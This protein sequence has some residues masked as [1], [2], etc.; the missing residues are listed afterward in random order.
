M[1]IKR[2]LNV[3]PYYD[4]FNIEKKYYR[5]LFKP[6]YAVQ[7]RE[8][9]Q[10]Q[11][12][13][14]NQIE[15]F[16]DNIFKEGSVI[17]GCTFTELKSLAY[18]K[19]TDAEVDG[20]P[21]TP[22]NYTD[23]SEFDEN[24][25]E[26]EY[27]FEVEGSSG[28]KAYIVTAT[29]G[30]QS[31]APDLNTFY[32][33]YLNSVPSGATD[34][35]LFSPGETLNV[36]RYK[37]TKTATTNPIT[38]V[39]T[40]TENP[41]VDDG[42]VATVSVASF[43]D[44]VGLSYGLSVTEGII[45]QRGHFLYSDAQTI[46]LTKYMPKTYAVGE[47]R[48]PHDISVGFMV[49]EE[50]I[51]SQ[52]DTSLLDNANG[53]ENENAPG[54]DRLK[55]SPVLVSLP[56]ADANAD[57]SFFTL[58]RYENG[59]ATLIRDVSQ[60][61]SISTEMAR[62]TFEESGDYVSKPF[63]FNTVRKNGVVNAQVG[64]G[65]VYSKGYRVQNNADVFLP[66]QDV[67]ST[68]FGTQNNQPVSFQYGGYFECIDESSATGLIDLAGFSRVNLLNSS[69]NVIGSAIVKDYTL[70]VTA[71]N[72]VGLN[73]STKGRLYVFGIRMVN[74]STTLSSVM[75]VQAPGATGKIKVDPNLKD[76]KNSKLVF[77][78]GQPFVK[79]VSDFVLFIRK[80]SE[81]QNVVSSSVTITPSAGETYTADCLNKI[82]V[83][84]QTNTRLPVTSRDIDGQG[85]IVLTI[86][87]QS[88][89]TVTVYHNARISPTSVRAKQ[90]LDCFV[91]TTFISSPTVKTKYTIGLPDVYKL[92]QITGT[93]SG[94][95]T[96]YTSSF[97][98]VPNQKDD[99][100]D[101]SYIELIAGKPTPPNGTVLTVKFSVFRPD[102]SGAYNF[103]TV[104]SYST[105]DPTLIP[106]FS[107]KSGVY[108]LR[109][110]IDL[111]PHRVPLT[112]IGY[113]TSS[114]SAPSISSSVDIELPA[115]NTELFST[116]QSYVYPA[117]ESPST[118]DIDYYYN[119]T[120]AIVASSLGYI[121]LVKGE[122]AAISRP[123]EV[124]GS[125]IIATV[126]VPGYPT[127]TM[128]EAKDRRK[129][130]Y[131]VDIRKY[132]IKN[133]T[134]KDIDDI[135]KKIDN[136]TYYVTLSQLEA[137]TQ[138]LLV[139]DA[140]GNTRF[141]NG[142][143][144]DP[145]NDLTIADINHQDFNAA[146]DFTE[147]S[148]SPS[149]Q[150]FPMNLKLVSATN[151]QS[152]KNILSTLSPDSSSVRLIGQETATNYRTCT[153]NFY[154]YNGEGF[155]SPEY[156]GAYDT[157]AEPM[158]VTI[159]LT[160]PLNSL[161][162]GIQEFLPLQSSSSRVVDSSSNT[163]RTGNQIIVDTTQTI[164]TT[165]NSLQSSVST[166]EQPV[167]DFVTNVSFEPFI[168]S[169]EVKIFVSGLRPNTRHYFFFDGVD[170]NANV[171]PAKESETASASNNLFDNISKS[172]KN[173]DAVRSDS[174]GQL[175]ASFFIPPEKFYVG[176]RK[177]EIVDVDDYESIA[178]AAQSKCT[179]TYHAYNFNTTTSALSISTR[180]PEYSIATSVTTDT[181][182]NRTVTTIPDNDDDRGPDPDP[183]G[184]VDPLAQTFFVKQN[185][186]GTNDCVYVSKIDLYFKRKSTVNGVT[187]ML[188]EVENGYPAYEILPFSKVHLKKSQV[189]VSEDGSVATTVTFSAPV[190]LN[191]EKEYC[192]VIMP[193]AAD[194]DYLIF[195]AKV[196]GTNL[197]TNEPIN[198]DWGDGVLF[199][200]TNDRAWQSYQDEDIK[201]TLYRYNFNTPTG[202]LT[203]GTNGPEFFTLSQYAN[204]FIQN[205]LVYALK[206]TTTF[207]AGFTAGFQT[208]TGAGIGSTYS[209]GDYICV[210]YPDG[211][212]DL[213]KVKSV[214]GN[215]NSLTTTEAARVT[216]TFAT[217]PC[218][219]A[220]VVNY[221]TYRPSKLILEESSAR[222][223][224][225]FATND[226]IIGLES[227]ATGKIS[228]I[229]NFEMSY[230]QP[231]IPRVTDK[232][233]AISLSYIAIDPDN[234]TDLPYEKPTVFNDKTAF[235]QK[236]AVIYSKSN[237]VNEQKGFKLKVSLN[238]NSTQT[239]TALVDIENA[240]MMV[241]K[242]NI[243]NNEN[244]PTSAYVSK[245]VTLA[246]GFD[247]ED[248]RLYVT[249]YLPLGSNIDAYIR[250]ENASDPLTIDS[251][252]WIPFDMISGRGVYSSTTNRNDFREYEFEI[253]NT[254]DPDD[255]Y[256]KTAGVIWYKN[257][258]GK[259][260]K[261]K[262]FQIKIVMRSN[263]VARVPRLLDYRGIAIE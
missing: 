23:Y 252:P 154:L 243:N 37:I 56:T 15:Q 256:G 71:V 67:S 244:N 179:L 2:D 106:T 70:P 177:L 186:A 246:D 26:V 132:G 42:I 123:P 226:S 168:R 124:K 46:V 249:A 163:T 105:I 117:Q 83:I 156:D 97:R 75:Y 167:G 151:T 95:T 141:K 218:V 232:K 164:Q 203:L 14:Q 228:T 144:V 66:I 136:L 137:E 100:Y 88:S 5:V 131:G 92:L 90:S 230:I 175:F 236:G 129:L 103:F 149:V 245:V 113:A 201:F 109:D 162:E 96:D 235:D 206:G 221:A 130:S 91:K 180:A 237:D 202:N 44:P 248:F 121:Y 128:Q 7:A 233:S 77:D 133:Y 120:D 108:D 116:S 93:T 32:V 20:T 69:E 114:G 47:Y 80:K 192:V 138:N 143:I 260:D 183:G 94:V 104:N 59:A 165:T 161:V 204:K 110:C 209:V 257:S 89:G 171:A 170:V 3:A 43:S 241:N 134:M 36:R 86:S 34:I 38:Q 251:N 107:G 58:R 210:P 150:T 261:Y 1:P 41:P 6:G 190:R 102:A 169:R 182:T 153:S 255:L 216:G 158:Q 215:N 135:N 19:L 13:L 72:T 142:I 74:N 196:G 259:Y 247:A 27:Y 81:N 4:D 242:Y 258:S 200:S 262:N 231:T 172:G 62:R 212:K 187:V 29:N 53:S 60:F 140:D 22:T 181:V 234:P 253:T 224:R 229:D 127:Y 50:I 194:P 9:T 193:D 240:M 87:G 63:R 8:L 147:R 254:D 173:G 157:V 68:S 54:A 122:E 115:Y 225:V 25:L 61:N 208:V 211:T 152:Y 51:N 126:Y 197:I 112:G 28:L 55:L 139:K 33:N 159:D 155:L 39:E 146:L 145:F 48:Q 217:R 219:A 239:S 24:G 214:A 222:S 10:L 250:I 195:T 191:V 184:R 85:R 189:N 18:V 65:I 213:L 78:L 35:K 207:S 188:R 178:S 166:L 12:I 82:V 79:G 84:S 185:F 11:T 111:R 238:N 119:R 45:F 98:L 198:Q 174:E 21:F 40:I 118:V 30:F 99:F 57:T 205:E 73:T 64:P 49:T 16:G 223:G 76:S 263:D 17:K 227:G 52:Q 199:T 220:K 160:G 148:I 125:T 31:K 101:H 176:D